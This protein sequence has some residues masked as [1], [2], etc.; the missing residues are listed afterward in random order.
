MAERLNRSL[1]EML[2]TFDGKQN[3]WELY[4]PLALYA[5]KTSVHSS[6]GVTPFSLMFG[7]VPSKAQ[8]TPLTEFEPGPYAAHL[9]ARL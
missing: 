1:L 9:K 7:G 5:Y 4:L 2:Q 8:F 3:D 6:T